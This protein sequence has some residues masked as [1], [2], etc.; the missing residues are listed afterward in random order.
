VPFS[1]D[2][3]PKVP[4]EDRAGESSSGHENKGD[5]ELYKDYRLVEYSTRVKLHFISFL[6]RETRFQEHHLLYL[7]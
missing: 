1:I 5:D 7:K 2:G 3:V 4:K 6:L